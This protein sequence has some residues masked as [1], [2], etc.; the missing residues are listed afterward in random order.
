MPSSPTEEPTVR[1]TL[2]VA[3]CYAFVIKGRTHGQKNAD[4]DGYPL[5]RHARVLKYWCFDNARGRLS[6]P[7]DML[8]AFSGFGRKVALA[9]LQGHPCGHVLDDDETPFDFQGVGHVLLN[10]SFF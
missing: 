6:L 7:Y 8:Q 9:R 10:K 4:R 1:K 3:T 2:T 5:G